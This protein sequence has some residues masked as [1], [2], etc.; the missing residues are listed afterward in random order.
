M[1]CR[2]RLAGLNEKLTT[3]ERRIE[4]LEARVSKIKLYS[5][6]KGAN[7]REKA[8]AAKARLFG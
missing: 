1:S 6:K 2:G 4:Y 5:K 3:L 8:A 7:K